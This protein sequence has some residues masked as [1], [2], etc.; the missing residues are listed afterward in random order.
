MCE[1]HT[2]LASMAHAAVRVHVGGVLRRLESDTVAPAARLD[3]FFC[4]PVAAAGSSFDPYLFMAVA[5]CPTP[6]PAPAPAARAR[7]CCGCGCV[8]GEGA[9]DDAESPVCCGPSPI[10]W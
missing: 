10:G 8:D 9:V 4:E 7:F 6:A 2:L 5:A 3:D 1:P